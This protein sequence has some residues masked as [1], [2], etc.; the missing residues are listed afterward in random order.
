MIAVTLTFMFAAQ[1]IAYVVCTIISGA[2]FLFWWKMPE[3]E[4]S[5][6][7]PRYGWFSGLTCAA[8]VFGSISTG[9]FMKASLKYYKLSRSPLDSVDAAVIAVA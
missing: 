4:R 9:T 6:L 7:W 1:I 5:G 2:V 3:D 8:G